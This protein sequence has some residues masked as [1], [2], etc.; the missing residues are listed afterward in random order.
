MSLSFIVRSGRIQTVPLSHSR[1]FMVVKE[2]MYVNQY[3]NTLTQYAEH[4]FLQEI[5]WCKKIN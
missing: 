5:K 1:I 4:N 2:V 3:G